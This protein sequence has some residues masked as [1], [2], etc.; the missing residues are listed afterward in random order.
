MQK[1][2]KIPSQAK[3]HGLEME[4]EAMRTKQDGWFSGFGAGVLVLE[5]QVAFKICGVF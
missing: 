1:T 2:S 3:S 5:R 4:Q